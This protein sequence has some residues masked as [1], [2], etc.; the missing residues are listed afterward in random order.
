MASMLYVGTFV[1]KLLRAK[2]KGHL[3]SLLLLPGTGFRV[4]LCSAFDFLFHCP[5]CLRLGLWS[6]GRWIEEIWIGTLSTYIKLIYQHQP[7]ASTENLQLR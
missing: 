7:A 4:S 6:W 3:V 2:S 5:T 1:Q